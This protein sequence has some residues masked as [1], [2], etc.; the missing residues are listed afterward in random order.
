MS[1]KKVKQDASIPAGEVI[2][3]WFKNP[4]FVAAYD[5][6]ED[7]FAEIRQQM[8]AKRARRQHRAMLLARLRETA[9]GFW[10]YIWQHCAGLYRWLTRGVTRLAPS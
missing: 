1:N 5:A 2:A 10:L 9:R 8:L 4:K 7:E 3:E 6:L